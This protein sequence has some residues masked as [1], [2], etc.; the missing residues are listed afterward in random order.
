MLLH[1]AMGARV[2]AAADRRRPPPPAA[3]PPSWP[4]PMGPCPGPGPWDPVLA[5]AHGTHVPDLAHGTP[6]RTRMDSRPYG[7]VILTGY[8]LDCRPHW[9]VVLTGLPNI[10]PY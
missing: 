3:R 8:S 4:W 1:E 5:L 9:I 7:I 6:S 10:S 2:V